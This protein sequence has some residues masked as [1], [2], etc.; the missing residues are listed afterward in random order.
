MDKSNLNSLLI[1]PEDM[2]ALVDLW[3]KRL[4][5]FKQIKELSDESKKAGYLFIL[6]S[7]DLSQLIG[8]KE[9]DLSNLRGTENGVPYYRP[10]E[11][12]CYYEFEEALKRL[13]NYKFSS[14][15]EEKASRNKK[16]Q[17]AES[18]NNPQH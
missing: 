3:K 13:S 9:K 17:E 4:D 15:K 1:A 2:E 5:Q 18:S 10:G 16:P 11:K 7:R 8:I 12:S 14:I 6:H